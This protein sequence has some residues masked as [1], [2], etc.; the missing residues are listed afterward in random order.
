MGNPVPIGKM[1]LQ[2]LVHHGEHIDQTAWEPKGQHQSSS[3]WR[4]DTIKTLGL[5]QLY[6]DEVLTVDLGQINVQTKTIADR[7]HGTS[8]DPTI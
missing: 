3:Y 4:D 7:C 5:I 6:A 1:F 2:A 8:L